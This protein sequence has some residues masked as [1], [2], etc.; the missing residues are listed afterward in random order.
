MLKNRTL[1][2]S[3]HV[4]IYFSLYVGGFFAGA[5][6]G[7]VLVFFFLSQDI[8]F[9]RKYWSIFIPITMAALGA[10]VPRFLFASRVSANCPACGGPAFL[11]GS[12]DPI[13]YKCIACGH[14]HSTRVQLGRVHSR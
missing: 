7:I 6:A 1:P 14:K 5:A 12:S 3:W 13:A 10:F 11:I 9:L 2:L 4:A 8:V